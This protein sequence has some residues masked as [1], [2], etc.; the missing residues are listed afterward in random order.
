[1]RVKVKFLI[2]QSDDHGGDGN[3]G[4]EEIKTENSE[5]YGNMDVK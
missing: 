1:M 4:G 3:N 2:K 5:R